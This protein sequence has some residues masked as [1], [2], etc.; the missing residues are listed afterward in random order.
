MSD[1]SASSASTAELPVAQ[2]SGQRFRG[3]EDHLDRVLIDFHLLESLQRFLDA[4][5][6]YPFV[7][8]REL[9]PGAAGSGVPEKQ[10]TLHNNGLLLLVDGNLP[11]EAKKHLRFRDKGRVV[12]ENLGAYR[13]LEDE[14][15]EAFEL[16]WTR[17]GG[18]DFER[19]LRALIRAD[20]GLLVQRDAR[21]TKK[22]RFALTHFRVRIDWPVVEATESLG[23]ELKFLAKHLFELPEQQ[24]EQV[25]AKLYERFGFHYTVG[26][27]RTAGVV[28]AQYLRKLAGRKKGFDFRVYVGSCESRT[29]TK[30]HPETVERFALVR[31]TEDDLDALDLDRAIRSTHAVHLDTDGSAVF[32]LALTYGLTDHAR[33]TADVRGSRPIDGL[34]SMPFLRIESQRLQPRF[35]R[36]AE[37]VPVS[38]VYRSTD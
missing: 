9:K 19:F 32:V 11:D 21:A 33:P 23:K 3:A 7:D 30:I 22:R 1:S 20:F 13:V 24:A 28:C 29:L 38:L 17:P 36:Q 10:V 5:R 35:D 27:R 26:G 15:L 2:G 37:P 16:A 14:M 25:E 34:A 6:P 18:P 4:G 12:K 8:M 31:L